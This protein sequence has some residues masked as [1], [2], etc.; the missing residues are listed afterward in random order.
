M[1][2]LVVDDEALLVKGIR[3]NLQHDGYEVITGSDG[4]EAVELA[5]S[6]NPDLIVQRKDHLQPLNDFPETQPDLFELRLKGLACDCFLIAGQQKICHL[7]ILGKTLSGCG[8]H[9]RSTLRSA[10]DNSAD[11]AELS[12]IRD[13]GASEFCND[14]M[15]THV[16]MISRSQTCMN[17]DSFLKA[18]RHT[19]VHCVRYGHYTG[20]A[21][22]L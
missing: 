3:F 13:R 12:S 21:I 22:L 9:Y 16:V 17:K 7:Y 6:Q 8:N 15:F 4:V 11:F 1:K 20:K 19:G 10:A 18:R 5:Q 14:D 2:I